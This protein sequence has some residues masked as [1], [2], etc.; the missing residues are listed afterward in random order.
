MFYALLT[1]TSGISVVGEA[2]L[3]E[4]KKHSTRTL[5]TE[6]LF[7]DYSRCLVFLKGKWGYTSIPHR[8]A[9]EM[10]ITATISGWC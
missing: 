2:P 10:Q 7:T 6:I 4:K 5:S 8:S 1:I 3:N 9:G